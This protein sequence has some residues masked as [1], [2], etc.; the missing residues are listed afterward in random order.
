MITMSGPQ[1]NKRKTS[2][3]LKSSLT[4]NDLIIKDNNTMI[5]LMKKK[6]TLQSYSF[7]VYFK[8]I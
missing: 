6:E 4:L 1:N 2:R 8:R 7:K 3:S 5:K